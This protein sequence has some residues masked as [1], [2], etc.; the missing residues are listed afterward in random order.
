[1]QFP[2]P[3]LSRFEKYQEFFFRISSS[4]NVPLD[5]WKVALRALL[6]NFCSEIKSCAEKLSCQ[7][8]KFHR[9]KS[10][11][12][13]KFMIV[14]PKMFICIRRKLLKVFCAKSRKTCAKKGPLRIFV[15]KF[16]AISF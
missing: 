1:M 12:M 11:E 8:P 16:S 3:Y 15:S 2:Q 10:K 9:S 6:K 13:S 14:F 4:Q 7:Y 5:R